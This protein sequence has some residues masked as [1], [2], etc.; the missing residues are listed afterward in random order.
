VWTLYSPLACCS[1]QAPSLYGTIFGSKFSSG[2]LRYC[3]VLAVRGS[4]KKMPEHALATK[5]P[6]EENTEKRQIYNHFV[7]RW[8]MK[9]DALVN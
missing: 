6:K 1:S 3:T 9:R 4:S 8:R 2:G 5:F 7:K